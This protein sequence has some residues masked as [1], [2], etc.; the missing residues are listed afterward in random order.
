MPIQREMYGT[1][2]RSHDAKK[3]AHSCA[4]RNLRQRSVAL[5]HIPSEITAFAAMSGGMEL[6]G[7][8]S[9]VRRNERS[10]L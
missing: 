1:D 10:T 3:L 4:R 8:D 6:D 7:G 5:F 2:E 9:C